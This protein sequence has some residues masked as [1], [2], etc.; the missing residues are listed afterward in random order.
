MEQSE[1]VG[2][3]DQALSSGADTSQFR[4]ISGALAGSKG[5]KANVNSLSLVDTVRPQDRLDAQQ[6]ITYLKDLLQCEGRVQDPIDD[7][8]AI[9]DKILRW[10]R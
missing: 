5:A 10:K 6:V 1:F 9:F 4:R 8:Q 7:I 2:L 3:L